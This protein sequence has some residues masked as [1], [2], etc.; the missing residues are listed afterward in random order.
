MKTRKEIE[1]L[2]GMNEL[3][4]KEGITDIVIEKNTEIIIELL[5][6]IRDL[7]TASRPH[8]VGE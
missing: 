3:S 7:L 1:L 2:M 8:S 4:I 5:L 6:D